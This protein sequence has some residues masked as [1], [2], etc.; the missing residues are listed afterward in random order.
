MLLF[1][2]LHVSR[3]GAKRREQQQFEFKRAAAKRSVQRHRSTNESLCSA[4]LPERGSA[5]WRG[6]LFFSETGI[7]HCAARCMASHDPL[8]LHY[9]A[10]KLLGHD[11]STQ[12]VDTLIPTL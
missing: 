10:K 11:V 6:Q 7:H 12:H 5:E 9:L 4:G 1:I 8:Q 3:R 2:P